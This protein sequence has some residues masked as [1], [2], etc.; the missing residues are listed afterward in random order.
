[1]S[2]TSSKEITFGDKIDQVR[3]ATAS[4]DDV[5]IVSL[6]E[7]PLSLDVPEHVF[8]IDIEGTSERG[9]V[10][11]GITEIAVVHL[12]SGEYSH[13]L[14]EPPERASWAEWSLQNTNAI[15]ASRHGRPPREIDTEI[16]AW[17][18]EKNTGGKPIIPVG[19][20]VA[21]YDVPTIRRDLP[22]VHSLLSYRVFDVTTM[23]ETLMWWGPPLDS[24][25]ASNHPLF[26]GKDPT[27]AAYLAHRAAGSIK[28][29]GSE[30]DPNL[31]PHHP[32]YDVLEASFMM[33]EIAV[34][35]N[36]PK[37]AITF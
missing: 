37:K 20:N 9:Q 26:E 6:G 21:S 18:M 28:A 5:A 34:I 10:D 30:L 29:L 22:M 32:I 27:W 17:M 25:V 12:V 1:M 16:S 8:G 19:K 35:L 24:F 11:A 4:T 2:N 14:I 33:D 36:L 3:F 23:M 31:K 7:L 13:A 15:A